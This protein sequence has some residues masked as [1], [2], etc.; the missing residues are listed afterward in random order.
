MARF[1]FVFLPP[2]SDVQRQWAERLARD[3]PEADVSVPESREDT[4]REIVDAGGVFGRLDPELLSLARDLKWLQA[5]AIAPPAGFYFDELVAHPSVATN[6]REIFNDHIAAHIMMYVLSFARG[7]HYYV[8]RQLAHEYRPARVDTG[9]VHLPEATAL[10]VGVGGIGSEAAKHC[11]HFGMQVLGIDAR[12]EDTPEGV[13]ELHRP[14][15]LDGLL[16]KA[17]FVIL[18]I[19][20]TPQTEGMFGRAKFR[21]MKDSAFFINIGRGKTTRLHDLDAA[22]R[23][24]E[25]AG[26]GL[27]VYEEEP[28]PK[29]HPLWT[30]PN[31][32]LTPHTAGFGPY[33]ND[34]RYEIL[35]DNARRFAA[36]QPL[37]NVVD[38]ANWF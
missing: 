11:T 27:D 25:I 35:V 26:A 38:K 4:R 6:F 32:I 10:I 8:R 30:A 33:L 12:R 21:A 31:T 15:E 37:R 22:L 9:V 34:R 19:P 7:M 5:P 2:V 24:G 17:D 29:D 1:K 14:E 23:A 3:V 20:H 18:T 36:G 28:L 16:P 13:A